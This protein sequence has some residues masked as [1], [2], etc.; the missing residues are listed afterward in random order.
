MAWR[1]EAAGRSYDQKIVL[2]EALTPHMEQR[3]FS[4]G[5]KEDPVIVK[6]V[7]KGPCVPLYVRPSPLGYDFLECRTSG[8]LDVTLEIGVHVAAMEALELE[9]YAPFVNRSRL[10]KKLPTVTLGGQN[11]VKITKPDQAGIDT[12]MNVIVE[13]GEAFWSSHKTLDDIQHHFESLPPNHP[14]HLSRQLML[15]AYLKRDRALFD[16]TVQEYRPLLVADEKAFNHLV[17]ELTKKFDEGVK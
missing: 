14:A 6:M 15:V 3:G 8:S 17:T 13:K 10:G 7:G 5:V 1:D 16:R 11:T 12:L 9:V 2:C 4:F